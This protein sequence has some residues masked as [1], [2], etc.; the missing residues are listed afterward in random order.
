M[1]T[2]VQ[3]LEFIYDIVQSHTMHYLAYCY[4]HMNT[5]CT[6]KLQIFLER[7]RNIKQHFGLYANPICKQSVRNNSLLFWLAFNSAH[8]T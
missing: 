3:K 6:T 7:K 5:V 2:K 8:I 4:I 1:K